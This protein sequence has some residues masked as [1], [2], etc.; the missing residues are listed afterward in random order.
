MHPDRFR[1]GVSTASYQI[2]GGVHEG[3]RGTSI[4]DTF[5]HEPGRVADGS[6]GDVACDH[7]HRYRDDVDVIAGLGADSY[8]FS[9]A[10]P[11]VQPTG[12]GAANAAG[13]AFYDRLVDT[14]LARGIDP[15]ATLFHWDLPQTLQDAG[16]WF[17]RDTAYRFADYADLIATALGDRVGMWIT[18][19][20]PF[21]HMVLGHALGTHAPGETRGL[22]ALPTAHHQL[23]GH[24]LAVTA[25]RAR[26]SSPIAIANNYSPVRVAGDTEADRGAA[27]V[28]D[29]LHNRLFTDP[30]FGRGYPEDFDLPVVDGDLEIIAAPIDAL[31]VNYY[32]PSGVRASSDPATPF[33]IVSVD[34]YPTTDFGWPVVPSGLTEIVDPPG[35]R[36]PDAHV[37]DRERL[38][39]RGKSRR[40]GAR[41]I[42]E[43]AHR[44]RR[45]RDHGRS[46]RPWLF[47]V[48]NH[49]QLRVGGRFQQTVRAGARR[50]RDAGA[51]PTGV[52]SLVPRSHHSIEVIRP[53]AT[54]PYAGSNRSGEG[55]RG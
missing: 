9:I 19:N 40:S 27:A 25:L 43:G 14:L 48:V 29:A 49:G 30:L 53:M 35:H 3:G 6:T 47:R 32:F 36:L 20:E 26:T 37:C 39:L 38:R 11:R 33:E 42:S 1:W 10:W 7:F 34:G 50:F 45:G 52:V 44:C 46:R 22:G 28:Y 13:V 24:G 55:R 51:H 5:S 31:G 23:L 18:L 16:G 2:E 54:G 12:R 21:I 4:W 8:R 17:E 41:R 15:V